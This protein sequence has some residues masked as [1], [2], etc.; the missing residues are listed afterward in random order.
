[1]PKFAAN[2][3]MLFQEHA[4]LDRFAAARAAGFEAVEIQF[5]YAFPASEIAR[6]LDGEGMELVLHNLPAGDW[7]AGER[8]L[9]AL[10]G[11]EVEFREGLARALDYAAALGCPRLNCLAG[12]PTPGADPE[13]ARKTF[14]GNLA[15]AAEALQGAGLMLLTEAINDRDMPGF[16]LTRTADAVA[17]VRAVGAPNVLIQYDAYHMQRMEGDLARTIEENL[18]FIGHIQIADDPGRHEPGTGEIDYASL[19]AHLDGIGYRGWVGCE[20]TPAGDTLAGLG[21]MKRLTTAAAPS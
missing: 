15:L 19:L 3:S 18:A 5:P 8:G 20:Y 9:A 2:L 14:V 4:F 16:H 21:W 11:R 6:R 17:A 13:D 10:A 7:E 1:M 12:R